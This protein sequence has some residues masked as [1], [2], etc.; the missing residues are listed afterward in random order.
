MLSSS[1]RRVPAMHTCPLVVED[2]A[3]GGANRLLQIRA[4]GEDNVG[5]LAA[6]FQPHALHIAV[7]GV[8]Q[9]LLAGAGG[10]GEGDDF[11]IRMQGQRLPGL[12]AKAADHVQHAV[13]QAGLFRQPGQ[14]QGGERRF[15]RG[16]EDYAIARRQR[17]A[18]FPA[19]QQ[20]GSSTAPPRRS[21]QLVRERSSP[22]RCCRWGPLRHRLYPALRHTSEWR[23]RAG[24]IVAQAVA[25]RLAGIQRF[26]Q[27]QLF[28]MGL[29]QISKVSEK[30]R[31]TPGRRGLRPVAVIK[32]LARGFHRPFDVG[33]FTAGDWANVCC[34]AGSIVSK[35]VLSAAA[36]Y[37]P[38]IN[39][40]VS[41]A[42]FSLF[43]ASK[44]VLKI[45]H[46]SLKTLSA[47]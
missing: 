41:M 32:S 25:N 45:H 28:T 2:A 20:Q 6:R 21:R 24:N 47:N 37:S 10:A 43:P 15:F 8:F 18:E 36:Q 33:F 27:R 39:K 40:R 1:S 11:N 38:L 35:V 34:A 19:G 29:H 42:G 22:A 30:K 13:R 9:Q 17:R 12:V 7:A 23:G 3:G 31:F 16:F 26:Q 5:A 46:D 44:P 4:V 14:T